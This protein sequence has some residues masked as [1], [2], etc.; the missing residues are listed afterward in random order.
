[1][2]LWCL[3]FFLS[4]KISLDP[5]QFFVIV[6]KEEQRGKEYGHLPH[7]KNKEWSIVLQKP[8]MISIWLCVRRMVEEMLGWECKRESVHYCYYCVHINQLPLKI[9]S[10][11]TT[12][13]APL[14]DSLWW[15]AGGLA[16]R[17]PVLRFRDVY[18][19][20]RILDPTFFHSGSRIRIFPIPDPD[21]HQEF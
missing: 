15:G 17:K 7:R 4:R 8:L 12:C 16:V 1:V 18:P 13:R 5:R 3:A 20:S 14:S 19:G 2:I 9:A 6:A 21:P 11:N 10:S